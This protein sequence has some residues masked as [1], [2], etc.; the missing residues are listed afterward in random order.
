M[1][2]IDEAR[3]IARLAR[4]GLNADELQR[5]AGELTRLLAHIDVMR[6]LPADPGADAP[7]DAGDETPAG[8]PDADT[9][10]VTPHYFAPDWRDGF[11]AAPRSFRNQAGS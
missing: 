10:H 6:A 1:V 11:F 5:L 8:V 7:M 4:L 9:L 3:R 2:G